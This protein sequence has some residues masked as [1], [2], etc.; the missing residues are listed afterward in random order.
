M[1]TSTVIPAS[2]LNK[3][4]SRRPYLLSDRQDTLCE[5]SNWPRLERVLLLSAKHSRWCECVLIV[6]SFVRR[7]LLLRTA[8]KAGFPRRGLFLDLGLM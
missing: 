3:G 6:R 5:T 4:R 8:R 2:P 1:A 7:I